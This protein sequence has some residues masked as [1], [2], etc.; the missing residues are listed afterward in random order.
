MNTEYE[1]VV[2]AYENREYYDEAMLIANSYDVV[3]WGNAPAI[4]MNQRICNNKLIF[5]YSERIF[6]SGYIR[7]LS[8]KW[9]RKKCLQHIKLRNKNV[10][11]LCA[12]AYTAQDM[13]L[14]HAY[15]NKMFKWGYFPEIINYSDIRGLINK[16]IKNEILWVARLIPYKHPEIA[17]LLANYLKKQG[18]DFHIN[19]IG[20]GELKEY[21]HKRIN[22][23][24]L[25]NCV[26]MLGAMSPESV[27][28]YMEKASVFIFTSDRNEGWGAVLNE[29]MNS[30]CAIVASDAIGSV[31]FLLKNGCNGMIYHDGRTRQL[32]QKVEWLLTHD[33]QRMEM[34][35]MAYDSLINNWNAQL[36]A[37]RLIEIA[38]ELIAG[39]NV[40]DTYPDGVCSVAPIHINSL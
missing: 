29:A 40:M 32:C 20:N 24:G 36:A 18:V 22:S 2:R 10:Y 38:S 3:I 1:F 11:M 35:V 9:F 37:S 23:E 27:R 19:I 28:E 31:P 39:K 5:R 17:I 16:K 30:G 12:S 21:I 33:D 4:F 15:K 34:G 25:E 14:I 7:L 13:S 26:S 8:P 6:K